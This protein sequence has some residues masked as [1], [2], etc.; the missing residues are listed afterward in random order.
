M[1]AS[2]SAHAVRRLQVCPR[3]KGIEDR[4]VMVRGMHGRC[5]I[6]VNGLKALLALPAV[7]TSGLRLSDIGREPMKALLNEHLARTA[8]ATTN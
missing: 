3:C 4:N 6:A 1:N 7:E 5:Y 2:L 8:S